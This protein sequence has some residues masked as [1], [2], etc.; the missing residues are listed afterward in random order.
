MQFVVVTPEDI[1]EA[2]RVEDFIRLRL[3]PRERELVELR[4][5]G[6]CDKLIAKQMGI[7]LSTVA[8]TSERVQKKM[9]TFGLRWGK[10]LVAV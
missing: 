10:I 7:S 3:A 9:K 1:T 4:S 6:L 8:S 2:D 5:S